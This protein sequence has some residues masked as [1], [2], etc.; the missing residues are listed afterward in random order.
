MTMNLALGTSNWI[1]RVLLDFGITTRRMRD[2]IR[3]I[4]DAR[5]LDATIGEKFNIATK[6]NIQIRIKY[7]RN[8]DCKCDSKSWNKMIAIN[9]E[10]SLLNQEFCLN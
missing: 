1:A 6:R 3:W 7:S 8:D 4:I 2:H 10:I 5:M 9:F